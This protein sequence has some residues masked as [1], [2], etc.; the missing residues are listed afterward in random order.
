MHYVSLKH[1]HVFQNQQGSNIIRSKCAK[2]WVQSRPHPM[3]MLANVGQ[4]FDRACVLNMVIDR[5]MMLVIVQVPHLAP[6]IMK[7]AT[8]CYVATKMSI[9]S[10]RLFLV[11]NYRIIF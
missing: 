11:L 8:C 2:R 6:Y 9:Q 1:M 10:V 7:Y 3:A 4:K 5:P